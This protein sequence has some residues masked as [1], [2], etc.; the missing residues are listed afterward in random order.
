[1]VAIIH[2]VESED[3]PLLHFAQKQSQINWELQ[4]QVRELLSEAR[5]LRHQLKIIKA[6]RNHWRERVIGG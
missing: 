2:N 6:E 1:M 5:E 3:D 4:E